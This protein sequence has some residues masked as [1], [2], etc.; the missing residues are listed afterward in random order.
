MKINSKFK[1]LYK[2]YLQIFII[3]IFLFMVLPY[4]LFGKN[5]IITIHDNLDSNI[6]WFKYIRDN[7]YYFSLN[8]PST[9]LDNLSTLYFAGDFTYKGLMY[10]LFDDFTAYI[11]IYISSLIFGFISMRK[12]LTI[13]LSNGNAY[14]I[15]F[16]SIL[17]ALIPIFPGYKIAVATLPYIGVLF[18]N[19]YNNFS[20]KYLLFAMLLPFFSS[21]D[22][23]MIFALGFWLLIAIIITIFNRKVKKELF[24]SFIFMVVTTVVANIRLFL[25]R[26]LYN[27]PLNRDFMNLSLA[28]DTQMT[29]KNFLAI[30]FKYFIKGHYHA[31]SVHMYIVIPI[32]IIF[33][34][35]ILFKCCNRNPVKS[36]LKLNSLLKIVLICLV[37]LTINCLIITLNDLNIIYYAF[38]IILP[39]IAGLSFARLYIFNNVLWYIIFAS[40]LS[41]LCSFKSIKNAVIV[42]FLLLI[43][44]YFII[45]MENYYQDSLKSWKANVLNDNQYISYKEFFSEELFD[46]VKQDI[47]YNGEIA[48]AVGYHPSVL[49]YNGFNTADGYISTYPYKDAVKFR[50]LIEPEL[51]VNDWAN[52]Y[53]TSW[54]GRRY[55]YNH[56]ISYEPTRE[57]EHEPI[58][59]NIDIDVFKN[60]YY[61]K[62]IISRAEVINSADLNLQLFNKYTDEDS[63]YNFWIYEVF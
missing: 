55:I 4:I 11:Y 38:K 18:Y 12:L 7:S 36:F 17:Y 54:M 6:P 48:I 49:M 32:T 51:M 8:K 52:R 2:Y 37:L 24:L 53:Y 60:E 5:C 1:S 61:G 29:L 59:L 26:L 30:F 39:P 31:N 63:I 20:I 15:N 10:F 40:E 56:E 57:K 33:F 58:Y 50:K 42:C 19:T 22:C 16:V 62:Y 28:T 47:K 3:A 25:M 27:E 13:I 46:K 43:Q 14:I 44:L 45:F 35:I 23:V 34:L 21:F 41:F 9:T